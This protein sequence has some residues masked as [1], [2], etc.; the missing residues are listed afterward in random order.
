MNDGRLYVDGA[1]ILFT[2]FAGRA[3]QFNEAGKA[4]FVLLIP[5]D[6]ASVL[7]ADGWYVGTLLP[8]NPED[9]P[10]PKINVHVNFNSAFPPVINITPESNLQVAVPYTPDMAAELDRL[11][12]APWHTSKF[13]YKGKNYAHSSMLPDG[14]CVEMPYQR[15]GLIINPYKNPCRPTS[16]ISACRPTSKISAYLQSMAGV[17]VEDPLEAMYASIPMDDV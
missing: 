15:L 4:N 14:S 5:E 7:T 16:K 11:R 9:A 2:N 8:K 10:R 1:R 17:I 13:T 6:L 3:T 12:F